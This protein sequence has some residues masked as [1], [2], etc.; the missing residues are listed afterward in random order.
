M[1][2]SINLLR[3]LSC[4]AILIFH[5][6]EFVILVGELLAFVRSSVRLH[7]YAM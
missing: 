5:I 4:F 7:V 1:L 6:R 3:T 2:N